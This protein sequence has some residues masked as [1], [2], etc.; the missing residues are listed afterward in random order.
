MLSIPLFF[1][2]S[3]KNVNVIVTNNSEVFEEYKKYCEFIDGDVVDVLT[4]CRDLVHRGYLLLM[5]PLAGSVK[6]NQS[7]YKSILL[8]RN[9]YVD[10]NSV[11]II[12]NSLNK[13]KTMIKD[14]N[15]ITNKEVLKDFSFLDKE[16]IKEAIRET[17]NL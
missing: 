17:K 9:E 13:V 10:I 5:H 7:P 8:K 11:I 1:G 16:L 3:M 6:P 4:R 15:A 2:G 12:E 14:K